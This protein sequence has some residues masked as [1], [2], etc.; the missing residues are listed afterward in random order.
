[1]IPS[2]APEIPADRAA[3]AGVA[4]MVPAGPEALVVLADPAARVGVVI[5]VLAPEVRAGL[6]GAVIAVPVGAAAPAVPVGVVPVVLVLA[7]AARVGDG[8]V[9]PARSST[10]GNTSVATPT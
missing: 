10:S 7:P 5:V 3:L 6:V 1:M 2:A 4:L 8:P 9:V